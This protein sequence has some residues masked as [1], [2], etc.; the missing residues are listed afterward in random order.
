[1]NQTTT[2]EKPFIQHLQSGA[3][4]KYGSAPAWSRRPRAEI[5]GVA[6]S[7]LTERFGSPLFVYSEKTLRQRIKAAN[8]AFKTRYPKAAFAWSY[9]TNYLNA[10]ATVFHQEGSL[11]EVVSEMEYLKA[12][13]LGIPDDQIIFN[14]PYKPVRALKRAA[15]K[16]AM[17]HIDH[18]DEIDDLEQVAEALG[19]K[20]PVAL[21]L[22]LDAGIYPQWNRF[23][24][25]LENGQALDAARRIH[26]GGHLRITG[27]HCHIGT[28]IL[29]PA[30]Y[31]T[32][33]EKMVRFGYQLESELDF[34]MEYFD[35][36][37]GFPSKSQLK[38]SYMPPE[39]LVPS[40]DQYAEHV[41]A[42]LRSALKP[43]D[44]PMIYLESGRALVDEAGYLITTNH[45]AKRMPD[46]RR[47]YILDAGVNL[48]YT[49]SWYKF[50]VELDRE[51]PGVAE[52]AVLNGPLCM[53]ID[54]V[55]EG[56]MLPP[57][58]R[59]TRLILSP[60]GAYNVT[61]WMQFIEFRPTVVMISTGGEVGV[62][63]EGEDLSDLNHREQMPEFLSQRDEQAR[64]G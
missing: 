61:Q 10:I 52:P 4:N 34:R 43:G 27:L 20:I 15:E 41:V 37:G 2:Y 36:G 8:D 60:I 1:M 12:R 14:G 17:I 29:D 16:G 55:D 6:I 58:P 32:Q 13:A 45:A 9:K 39:V 30:A 11:A 59:G 51:V 19:K 64:R 46:G 47:S 33:I 38:G 57:L 40:I 25:N 7:E 35:L 56:A 3:M 26:M 42:G 49:S 31:Q 50:N 48:L 28:F 24:F 53:N 22:N 23:G 18:F 63:R 44:Y 62:I 21:R 5:E 54:V